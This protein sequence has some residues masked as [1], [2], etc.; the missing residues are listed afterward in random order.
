M[1]EKLRVKFSYAGWGEDSELAPYVCTEFQ[2]EVPNSVVD[3]VVSEFKKA[4]SD[5]NMNAGIRIFTSAYSGQQSFPFEAF[6]YIS[7]D[8]LRG[9]ELIP[10][11]AQ[12]QVLARRIAQNAASLKI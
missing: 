2:S 11:D 9:E 5:F 1:S 6:V 10:S 3:A 4:V 12:M 7:F 8:E